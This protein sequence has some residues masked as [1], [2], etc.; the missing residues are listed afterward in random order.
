M[1][2][3]SRCGEVKP[4]EKFYRQNQYRASACQACT[5]KKA[6][7]A[8]RLNLNGIRQKQLAEKKKARL[9][10]MSY[11]SGGEPTCACCGETRYEFLSLDHIN[12]GGNKHRIALG[13]NKGSRVYYWIQQNGYPAG[14]RVLCYNCNLSRGFYGIC[15]HEVESTTPALRL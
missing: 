14:F 13:K 1:K 5:R 4:V 12:G 9:R 11:Y 10:V 2:R 6:N 7:E 3:C 8:Y 15:P